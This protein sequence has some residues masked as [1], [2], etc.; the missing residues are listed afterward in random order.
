MELNEPKIR[1]KEGMREG[2]REVGR[3]GVI[4][5]GEG[6]AMRLRKAERE[7]KWAVELEQRVASSRYKGDGG[8]M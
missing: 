1:K 2:R 3:K 5:G 7:V 8:K 4:G 6:C